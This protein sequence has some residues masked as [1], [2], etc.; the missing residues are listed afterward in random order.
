MVSPEL[1]IAIVTQSVYIS[2]HPHISESEFRAV[3]SQLA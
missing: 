1:M 3:W 2:F